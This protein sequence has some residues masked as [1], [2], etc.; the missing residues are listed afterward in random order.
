[1]TLEEIREAKAHVRALLAKAEATR[2]EPLVTALLQVCV[3]LDKRRSDAAM[4]KAL[5]IVGEK[6]GGG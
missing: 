6:A 4:A 2:D 1:M 3:M 5:E